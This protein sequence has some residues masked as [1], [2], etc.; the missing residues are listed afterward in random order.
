VLR[1]LPRL[2]QTGQVCTLKVLRLDLVVH[3]ADGNLVRHQLVR[4]VVVIEE[5]NLCKDKREYTLRL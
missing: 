4:H 1:V 2:R 3:E 5:C